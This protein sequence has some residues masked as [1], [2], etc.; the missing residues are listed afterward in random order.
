MSDVWINIPESEGSSR[1]TTVKALDH[2]RD[3]YINFIQGPPRKQFDTE[4]YTYTLKDG[5]RVFELQYHHSMYDINGNF[6]NKEPK[7]VTLIRQVG[8]G[9][10]STMSSDEAVCQY[11]ASIVN[12]MGDG[13]KPAPVSGGRKSNRRKSNRRKSNRRK[14]NRRK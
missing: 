2:Q 9:P 6:I 4:K 11:Y 12:R 3:A 14:S 1:E 7:V 8:Y 5:K 10:S 13:I